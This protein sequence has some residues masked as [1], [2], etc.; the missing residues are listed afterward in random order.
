M[1]TQENMSPQSEDRVSSIIQAYFALPRAEYAE[2]IT[3]VRE[4][5]G[6]TPAEVRM[7]K[8][9]LLFIHSETIIRQAGLSDT[10]ALLDRSS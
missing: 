2:M 10:G 9:R 1:W 6:L 4:K 7:L 8:D 5:G 3:E